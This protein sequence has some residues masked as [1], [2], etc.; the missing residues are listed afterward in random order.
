VFQLD[1]S[2]EHGARIN[3]ILSDLNISEDEENDDQSGGQM[4]E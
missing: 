2:I 1:H 4:A 3:Q